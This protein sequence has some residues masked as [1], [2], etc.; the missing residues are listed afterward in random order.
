MRAS[1]IQLDHQVQ[2]YVIT[3]L[4]S[5]SLQVMYVGT[6]MFPFKGISNI[7][8]FFF[9]Q[10]AQIF[11]SFLPPLYST[12]QWPI[13]SAFI[14]SLRLTRNAAVPQ[15]TIDCALFSASAWNH[16]QCFF[17]SILFFFRSMIFSSILITKL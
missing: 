11:L 3:L 14:N 15:H 13:G 2:V 1:E 12:Q 16:K 4:L 17:F 9:W 7:L 5:C 6:L 8:F 10:Y